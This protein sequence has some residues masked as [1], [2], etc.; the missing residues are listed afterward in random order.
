MRVHVCV[1]SLQTTT[2]SMYLQQSIP[3]GQ[4]QYEAMHQECAAMVA[5][6]D[7]GGGGGGERE[8]IDECTQQLGIKI[9]YSRLMLCF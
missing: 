4:Q 1:Y 8:W 6:Q 9:L 3:K 5:E 2:L 7:I